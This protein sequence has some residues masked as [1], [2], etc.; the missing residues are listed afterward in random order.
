MPRPVRRVRSR[1]RQSSDDPGYARVWRR[2]LLPPQKKPSR[3]RQIGLALVVLT[4]VA[5]VPGAA[6]TVNLRERKRAEQILDATGVK[7]G[8]IVHVGCGDGTLTAALRPNERY[9]VHGLDADA[10]SVAKARKHIRSL[11]LYGNVTIDLLDGRQFPYVDDLVN[12]IVAEDIGRVSRDE[13]MRALCPGGVAY[14]KQEGTW[15][16]LRKP[17]P[18]EIDEWS[19]FLHDASNNAVAQ[20]T[21]VG[22]PRRLKWKCGPAWSRS[23][24]FSS[25]IPAMV[26]AGGRIF[27]V[28]D[29]GL[30][31]LTSL[32]ERW[33]LV[34]RDAFNGVLLWKR[35]L[36]HWRDGWKSTAL[37]GRPASMPRW[38]VADDQYL[39]TTTSFA[40]GLSIL[41][42]ATGQTIRTV[43]GTANTREIALLARTLLLRLSG[44]DER[45]GK[46]TG[47]IVAI[48]ADA[49][50]ILWRADTG[51]YLAQSLAADDRRVVYSTGAETVCLNLADGQERWRAVGGKKGGR[52]AGER[53]FI[54][55]GDMVL[56]GDGGTIVARD[57]DTG[58]TRWSV[59]TGGSQAMRSQDMFVVQDRVWHTAPGG[60]AG[61]DLKTGKPTKVI[62]PSSVD[63][64]GHHLRCYR[65][66][67]TKRFLITQFRG[68]EFVSLTD[69]DHCN[70]D[71]IRGACRYGVMPCNGLLYVPPNPCFCY[72]GVKVTG[73]LALAPKEKHD[74][75][76]SRTLKTEL[77]RGPAYGAHLSAL[78]S[79]RSKDWP[80]YRHDGRRSGATECEVSAD[81]AVQW[82]VTLNGKLT[83]PVTANG[84]VYVA[85][86]DEQTLYTLASEDG[87]RLWHFTAGGR[88]D[89]PPT[90]CGELVIFGCADG[91]VCCVHDK[92]GELVWRLRLA[93]SRQ[94]IVA[95]DRLESPWRVHG[96]VLLQEGI[97]YC[98]AGRS[99]F[100]DG[101]IRIFGIDPRSGR[102]VHQTRLDTWCATRRD[103][104]GKPFIPS[105][106]MEGSF[107]DVLV[108]DGESIYLT[109]MKFDGKLAQQQ[110]PYI[111][112]DPD[113]PVIAMDIT[114]EGYTAED[115]D[116]KKGFQHFRSFHR[117]MEKAHP[118]LAK[119]YKAKYGH[120]NMGDR[121]TGTHL[122]ATAG[123]LDDTWFNRTYWMRSA[124]W[125]GWY[126]AHRGAKS[127]QLLVVGPERTYAVQA[128]PTRNRQSP[129][130][131]PGGKGYLLLADANDTEPV[132]DDL[133]RGATK[134]MGYTR[135]KPPVWYDWVPIR[136]RGMVLAGNHLFVAGSPDIVDPSDPMAAFEGRRGA[137]LRTVSAA[138]GKKLAEQK[139]ASPPVFDG[140]IAAAGRLYLTLTNGEVLCLAP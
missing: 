59:R 55:F 70:N 134:G 101:G 88:I 127:G 57:A 120:M 118:K 22:P 29:E 21:V 78:S 133:T 15:T 74:T 71:W 128:F 122:V 91:S 81:V 64:S 38:I 46:A 6:E 34:A 7:G 140:L 117:Y 14:I 116:V 113:N 137:V 28:V 44:G 84:R 110:T 104:Q 96:S 42:A 18:K 82:R 47:A 138:D 48:D 2:R 112:R 51:A 86:K 76:E 32:P 58:E 123:F 4:A 93:A 43:D 9:L 92:T 115:P 136:V 56:E 53:T 60:I 83:P 108:G 111:G 30:T 27:Y 13:V 68:A 62:D 90:I 66:K 124:N 99:T 65:A 75:A 109:Q 125:P 35:P 121:R 67:A 85:A 52:R 132:L 54:L 41:D 25:S 95:F 139:L 20:D 119:Q 50:K 19:H 45:R 103:A 107:S 94:R 100:L 8:L 69:D 102:V 1:I 31:S 105:Y 61:Y 33:T 97:V 3:S 106:H 80:A 87:R 130:F 77:E 129:L 10:A 98:T 16:T 131:T 17:W 26:S 36:P 37:R 5:S 11:G 24:E 73:L 89:S 39:Y 72:P 114:K 63:T 40:D 23:H 12:L 135:L 49:G 79:P 126:H